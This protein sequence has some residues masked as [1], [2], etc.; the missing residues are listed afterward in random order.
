MTLF[1]L[2]MAILAL[3]IILGALEQRRTNRRIRELETAVWVISTALKNYID[4]TEG[5]DPELAKLIKK[6]FSKLL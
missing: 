2:T 6:N 3:H 5:I 4:T 1:D